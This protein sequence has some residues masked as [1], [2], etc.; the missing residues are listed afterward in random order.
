MF[1]RQENAWEKRIREA[2][3][4]EKAEKKRRR[5]QIR[6]ENRARRERAGQDRIAQRKAGG[7][8]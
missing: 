3:E 8:W 5:A 6:E 4:R 2:E 7:W 1:G